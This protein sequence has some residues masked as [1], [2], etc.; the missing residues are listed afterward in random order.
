MVPVLVLE[1]SYYSTVLRDLDISRV[2]LYSC[3]LYVLAR[4]SWCT[5]ATMHSTSTTVVLVVVLRNLRYSRRRN[6]ALL[7]SRYY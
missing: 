4:N 1:Y 7:Y 6:L 3:T 5:L 2:R